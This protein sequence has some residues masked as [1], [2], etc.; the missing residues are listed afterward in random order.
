MATLPLGEVDT[1]QFRPQ[2]G[3]N[4]WTFRGPVALIIDGESASATVSFAG[5]FQA[6]GRG[7]VLGEACMGP[8]VG[9]MG[10]PHLMTLPH[11]RIVVSISTAV[12]MA[13]EC[14]DWAATTPIQPDV[15]FPAMWQSEDALKAWLTEWE[16][17]PNV[18]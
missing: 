17:A 14:R 8:A 18:P 3:P 16:Q 4:R 7:P 1:L 15:P 10:N 2:P 12:Y 6:T 11:S 5:A 9:T 13:Q